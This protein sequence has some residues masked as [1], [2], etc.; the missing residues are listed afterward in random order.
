MLIREGGFNTRH[1]KRGSSKNDVLMTSSGQ[2]PPD[3]K[4]I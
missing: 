2:C 4:E 1:R 3:Y